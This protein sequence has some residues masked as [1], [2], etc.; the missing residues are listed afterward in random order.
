MN[1]ND[2]IELEILMQ[3]GGTADDAEF[4]SA[5]GCTVPELLARSQRREYFSV[6]FRGHRHWPR[7]Q[8]GLAGLSD[9]LPVLE[10]K[11]VSSL[12]VLL[13][14]TTPTDTLALDDAVDELPDVCDDDSPLVLLRRSGSAAIPRVLRH[15]QRFGEQGAV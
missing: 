6:D 1:D 8:I 4:A 2:A 7:W 15:A 14:F 10:E 3:E 5:V 12:S 11:G 9:V 13:F